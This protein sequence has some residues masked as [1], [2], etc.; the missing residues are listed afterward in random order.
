MSLGVVGDQTKYATTELLPKIA[1]HMLQQLHRRGWGAGSHLEN[2]MRTL[3]DITPNR[4]VTVIDCGAASYSNAGGDI[5]HTELA[6]RLW[7]ENATVVGFEPGPVPHQNLM[8]ELPGLIKETG[9]KVTCYWY[10]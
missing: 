4:P 10:M 8:K 7:G 5:S 2:L 1:I 6:A 9:A 3:H